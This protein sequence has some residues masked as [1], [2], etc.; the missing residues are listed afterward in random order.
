MRKRL[1]LH[2]RLLLQRKLYKYQISRE[3]KDFLNDPT[4]NDKYA[5]LLHRKLE[6]TQQKRLERIKKKPAKRSRIT[7]KDRLTTLKL[8]HK[9]LDKERLYVN[10]KK[11]QVTK[12]K[13]RRAKVSKHKQL[14][15]RTLRR[16]ALRRLKQK[17]EPKPK[18]K[19]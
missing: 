14:V 8:V 11:R 7:R 4:T 10:E 5:N 2:N 1:R 19:K 13:K 17:V 15:R 3:H 9:K 6:I 18:K 16:I 12:R